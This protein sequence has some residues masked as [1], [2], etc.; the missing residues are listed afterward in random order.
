MKPYGDAGERNATDLFLFGL[1][2]LGFLIGSG[3]AVMA[4]PALAVSGGLLLLVALIS[5]V[6]RGEPGD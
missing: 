5:L 1:A 6:P 2:F 3:G 4:S